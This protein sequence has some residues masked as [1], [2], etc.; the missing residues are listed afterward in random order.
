[1][2]GV[3]TEW[4]RAIVQPRTSDESLSITRECKSLAKFVFS[5]FTIHI[6]GYLRPDDSSPLIDPSVPSICSSAVVV[7]RAD[8]RRAVAFAAVVRARGCTGER[9]HGRAGVRVRV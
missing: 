9:A 3:S 1:M 5:D 6:T 2:T 7:G 8:A 4:A